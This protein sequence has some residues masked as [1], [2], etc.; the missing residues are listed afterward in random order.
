MSPSV[1]QLTQGSFDCL[2][3]ANHQLFSDIA[4]M[5]RHLTLCSQRRTV[6]KAYRVLPSHEG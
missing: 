1:F 2:V 3:P 6:L 4:I 5:L